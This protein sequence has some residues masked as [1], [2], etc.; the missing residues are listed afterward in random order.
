MVS[1]I[2]SVSMKVFALI[3]KVKSLNYPVTLVVKNSCI[4]SNLTG[5]N[6]FRTMEIRRDM[7]CSNY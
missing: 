4:K 7:G 6:I 2:V 5:S 1:A 3:Q